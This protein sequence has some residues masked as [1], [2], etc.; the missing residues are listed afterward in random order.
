ME[1][2][3]GVV[4]TESH[5]TKKPYWHSYQG[6]LRTDILAADLALHYLV[7]FLAMKTA[8]ATRLRVGV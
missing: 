4:T 3:R 7:E 8:E 1:Y 5:S 2:G 6:P